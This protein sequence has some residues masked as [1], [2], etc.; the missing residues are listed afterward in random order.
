MQFFPSSSHVYSIIWMHHMDIKYQE[1]KLDGNCTRMLQAILNKSWKQHPTKQLMYSHLPPISKIIQI[2][3]TR[4]VRHCWRSK[5]ELISNVLQWTP[6]HRR[7]GVGWPARTYL[8]Q[9]CLDTG[10][11]LE[12]LP[13]TMDNREKWWRR[14]R[15][16]CT[17]DLTWWWWH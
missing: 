12:D 13:H 16:I 8:Q 14:V 2:K 3:L 6:S 11:S 10:Y 9:L 15:K 7:V 17:S 1:K 5:D 4:H